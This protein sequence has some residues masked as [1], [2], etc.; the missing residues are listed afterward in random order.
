MLS[1]AQR[2]IEH[3][4]NLFAPKVADEDR[5][6]VE[7]VSVNA[8]TLLTCGDQGE[9]ARLYDIS[10]NGAKVST[11]RPL[12]LGASVELQLLEVPTPVAARVVHVSGTTAGLRFDTPGSGLIIAG[13]SRGRSAGTD[14]AD[15]APGQVPT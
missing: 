14:D 8:Q 3:V 11:A 6:R 1:D 13:W 15:A 12:P 9:N 4:R 2:L 10:P 5:R 7:R